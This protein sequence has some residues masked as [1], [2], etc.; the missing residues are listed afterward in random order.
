MTA[1]AAAK[2]R[3]ECK[4]EPSVDKVADWAEAIVDKLVDGV[5]SVEGHIP[6]PVNCVHGSMTNIVD[7]VHGQVSHP[8]S[9]VH[10]HVPGGVHGVHHSLTQV[11]RHV[12]GHVHHVGHGQ[13]AHQVVVG[14]VVR[15]R[16]AQSRIVV[17]A[18]CATG[19]MGARL[20]DVVDLPSQ[21]V[22]SLAIVA[23]VQSDVKL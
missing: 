5:D 2:E 8:M 21:N 18:T 6:H 13:H 15:V 11:V 17:G 22:P 23:S 19:A 20:S 3:R 10:G 16:A 12:H 4:V 1:A 9:S 14:G 7:S